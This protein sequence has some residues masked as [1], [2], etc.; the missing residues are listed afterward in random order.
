MTDTESGLV[1]DAPDRPDTLTR[2]PRRPSRSM[3]D[4]I[5]S[6]MVLGAKVKDTDCP[7]I[8]TLSPAST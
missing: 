3:F 4:C 8:A 6:V 5:V 1:A 2:C 7:A